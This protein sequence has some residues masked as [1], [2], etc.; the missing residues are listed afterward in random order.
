[1]A[2]GIQPISTD[3]NPGTLTLRIQNN[4]GSELTKINL[5]FTIYV[6]NDGDRSSSFDCSASVDGI[7][8]TP[9]LTFASP[10]SLDAVD[11][12]STTQSEMVTG[13]SVPP[14]GF[15]YV[16]WTG[17]DLGGSGTRDEFALDDVLLSANN[18]PL[19][20]EFI[21]LSAVA[22]RF[23]ARLGWTTATEIN[24]FGFDIERRSIGAVEWMYVGFVQGSGTTTSPNEYSFTDERVSPGRHAYRIKQMD[25]NGAFTYTTA[26]EVEVGLA[27]K[28]FT[29]SQNYPNPFNPTTTIE[30]TLPE[31]G[32][33]RLAVYDVRGRLVST[34]I[35]EDRR[36]GVYHQ[37]VFVANNLAS[38]TYLV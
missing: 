23:N 1:M 20:V 24:N 16:R 37:A 32:H 34:L 22:D 36:A 12:I 13:L 18:E 29:L 27:P 9:L 8:Y 31:D 26:V 38:G 11:F 15:V 30:F 10:A 33:V 25:H 5:E 28:E 14:D 2:F 3:W 19:P 35:D 7:N 17:S 4:T 21:A 6:R